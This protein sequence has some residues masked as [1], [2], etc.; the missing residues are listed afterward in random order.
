MIRKPTFPAE[1]VSLAAQ[2]FV[3]VDGLSFSNGQGPVVIEPNWRSLGCYRINDQGYLIIVTQGGEIWIT[4][5]SLV[6]TLGEFLTVK[7]L[8]A[9]RASPV[10]PEV[11]QQR[12]DFPLKTEEPLTANDSL[13]KSGGRK[14]PADNGKKEPDIPSKKSEQLL[15]RTLCPDGESE[16]VPDIDISLLSPVDLFRRFSDPAWSPEKNSGSA[17]S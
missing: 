8:L 15:I 6:K 14:E 17:Q 10:I 5:N 13:A 4:V 1:R 9:L 3:R 11:Y 12:I 2:G 7:Q 16:T